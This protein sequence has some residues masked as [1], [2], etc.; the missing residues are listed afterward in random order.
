MSKCP[1]P[2][3]RYYI[4]REDAD[5]AAESMA[6]IFGQPMY[7]YGCRC[8]RL[9]LSRIVVKKKTPKRSLEAR[10]R[11]RQRYKENKR[12]RMN[13]P[14]YKFSHR[15]NGI[16]YWESTHKVDSRVEQLYCGVDWFWGGEPYFW[17]EQMRKVRLAP[18]GGCNWQGCSECFPRTYKEFL[19]DQRLA[20]ANESGMDDS[21]YEDD[22][23]R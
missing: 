9:H 11:R 22:D 2:E 12:K 8:G 18:H 10:R 7:S 15:A 19:A 21:W 13:K 4:Y 17:I 5:N 3:K 16:Y 14:R 1:H 6:K 20:Q 23:D